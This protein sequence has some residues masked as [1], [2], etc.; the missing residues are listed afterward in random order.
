MKE[1]E[2]IPRTPFGH[3]RTGAPLDN[4][5]GVGPPGRAG[6][7]RAGTWRAGAGVEVAS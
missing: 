5:S 4:G 3:P 1:A 2:V 7:W 6:T